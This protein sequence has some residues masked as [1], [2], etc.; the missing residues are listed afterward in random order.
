M[1]RTLQEVSS[2]VGVPGPDSQSQP[3]KNIENIYLLGF[4]RFSSNL[5]IK[6]F[7]KK[8]KKDR[9]HLHCIVMQ[10][11]E[12]GIRYSVKNTLQLWNV[13]FLYFYG[14]LPPVQNFIEWQIIVV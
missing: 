5:I 2:T 7:H 9:F 12:F 4:S 11:S 3:H 10:K 13:T 6:K 8:S 14:K 1:H